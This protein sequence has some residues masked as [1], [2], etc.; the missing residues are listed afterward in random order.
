MST[1]AVRASE[2]G[3]TR[4]AT[5]GSDLQ[6]FS[7]CP[8]SLTHPEN[9]LDKVKQVA[10]WSERAGC[11][12]TLIY[13]DNTL[14]DPWMV[15]QVVVE[16][17]RSLSPLVAVQ[18]V[19]MHP[20]SAA[21]MA[22]TIGFFYQRRVFFNMVAG[23]FKND[24]IALNDNTPH[25]SR[26]KR[27][28]EYTLVMRKLL[29]ERTPVTFE[30]DFYRVRNLQMN[31]KLPPSL[32]PRIL[33]SGSSEAGMGAAR[34][35]GAIAVKYP[36]PPG[37]CVAPLDASQPCGI[38]IGVIARST[39]AEAWTVAEERF[40]E[41]RKGQLTRQ[42]ATKISDSTWHKRLAEV[43]G[44]TNS[45]QTAE[46][47]AYWLHPFENYQ[48][49]CPY[50]VGDY[51]TVARELARYLSGGYRTFILDIPAAEQEFEHINI[52]FGLA[53]ATINAPMGEAVGAGAAD[54]AASSTIASGSVPAPGAT[55]PTSGAG[56]Q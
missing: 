14:V 56:V 27:L 47:S 54:I 9:Y 28:I 25:D 38:R 18:P 31:P 21:K 4:L 22:A 50:L 11:T 37:E 44:S 46:R 13:T 48:T 26:Y 35:M 19:Y 34:E 55:V 30:G 51:D 3:A 15:A 1:N 32:F 12:G 2:I 40:P 20:Y 5:A 52:V 43:G 10:Q 41:D 33:V 42:L 23:G 29:E 45:S 7:T 17:T 6:V 16:N 39:S 8:S 49:N 53:S 36:E 24:L